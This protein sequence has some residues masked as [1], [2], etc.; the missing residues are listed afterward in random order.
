M[1]IN[2]MFSFSCWEILLI[3][4]LSIHETYN[5][6]MQE[7][8]EIV[9][10]FPNVTYRIWVSEFYMDYVWFVE[11]HFHQSLF[12]WRSVFS[13]SPVFISVF[14]NHFTVSAIFGKWCNYELLYL[15][16]VHILISIKQISS[17]VLFIDIFFFSFSF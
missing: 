16:S 2:V 12:S 8:P 9:G 1:R 11:V 6:T 14:N 10:K 13:S 15:P 4:Q 5:K 7:Y 3:Q 17:K